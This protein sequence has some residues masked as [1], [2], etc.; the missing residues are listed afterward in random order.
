MPQETSGNSS[1]MY[2]TE[3]Q[4]EA[5]INSTH[6]R[7]AYVREIGIMDYRV[8]QALFFTL[9]HM[10]P[11]IAEAIRGNADYDPYYDSDPLV[12][13]GKITKFNDTQRLKALEI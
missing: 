10:H 11:H 6:E 8:G 5:V 4:L 9:E 2:L 13:V 7:S 1:I 12:A 3:E